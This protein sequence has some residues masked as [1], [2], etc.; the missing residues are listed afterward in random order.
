MVCRDY[1]QLI[2]RF[3]KNEL[4]YN[5]MDDFVSHV[6]NCNDCKEEF[7]IYYLSKYAMFDDDVLENEINKSSKEI[8]NYI[9]SF[10]FKGLVLYKLKLATQKLA[11]IAKNEHYQ[12]CLFNIAQ[13]SVFM[14]AIFYILENYF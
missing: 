8:S 14:M 2:E 10:D 1:R 4:D 7:E 6:A 9:E 11:L 3:D 13:F 5:E 12:K